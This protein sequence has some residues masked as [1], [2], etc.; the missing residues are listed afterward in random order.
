MQ[1][2]FRGPGVARASDILVPGQVE[3][4]NDGQELA[5]LDSDEGRLEMELTVDRGR[6]YLSSDAREGL[7]IGT[8]PVDAIFTPI[9]KVNYLVEH[10]TE[11]ERADLDRLV[12]EIWTDGTIDA[13]E[14][15]SLAA[16]ALGQHSA[17]LATY[18][19]PAAP[20]A[21]RG[22]WARPSAACGRDAHRRPGPQRAH[23]QLPEA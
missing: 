21:D 6:G 7:P 17:L 9:P 22:A 10:V 8:I 4:I 12:L 2:S 18:S 13:G 15:L 23:L 19:T 11:E 16:Q 3:L 20:G 5:T 1:L 14:A